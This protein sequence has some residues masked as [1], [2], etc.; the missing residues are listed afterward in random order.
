MATKIK[1]EQ[2]FAYA[3]LLEI[4]SLME[5]QYVRKV[6]KK[7][8]EIFKE[9]SLE[10][11]EKHL[12]VTIP[13]EEQN[14]SKDTAA[15]IGMLTLNYWCENEEEK[16]ELT[17]VYKENERKYQD[18]IR[19][20]YNPDNI[21]NNETINNKVSTENEQIVEN[22]EIDSKNLPLDYNSFPWYKKIFTKVRT[23]ILRILKR[24]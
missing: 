13:L 7:L 11:Y 17:S 3:E 10:S 1:Q 9:N 2:A 5:E 4:L 6:P 14:I 12:D 18:Q 15:L 20:K 24:I 23:F 8:I 19:E 16:I 22:I 21:F